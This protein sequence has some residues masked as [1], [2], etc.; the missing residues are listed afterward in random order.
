MQWIKTSEDAPTPVMSYEQLEEIIHS[1]GGRDAMWDEES[2]DYQE[3]PS[4]Y[5]RRRNAQ[6]D[7]IDSTSAQIDSH[8]TS[9][10]DSRVPDPVSDPATGDPEN[11]RLTF[12]PNPLDIELVVLDLDSYDYQI[13]EF[14][15]TQTR[16]GTD[17][18]KFISNNF[19]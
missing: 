10:S 4:G 3:H 1:R 14:L 19:C 2:Y 12:K 16:E 15:V 6:I 11:P 5:R 17:T 7:S 18:F 8:S 13:L 9:A